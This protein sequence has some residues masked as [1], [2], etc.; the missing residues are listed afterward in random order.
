MPNLDPKIFIIG[1]SWVG[2]MVMAQT[3]FKTLKQNHPN[4]IIDVMAPAWSVPLMER[5]PEINQGLVLPFAHGQGA[6]RER[7]HMGKVLRSAGYDRAYVLPNSWKSALIPWAAKIPVRTGWLG[8]QRHILLNDVRRLDKA[9]YPLMIERF[10]ALAGEPNVPLLEPIPKP[11]FNIAEG[12]TAQAL[13][14]HGLNGNEKPI[15]ALCPGSEFGSSKRWPPEYFADV[16]NAKLAEGWVVWLF[17]S[18]KDAEIA[19]T[20][21]E[22]TQNRCQNLTGETSLSEAVDLMSLAKALVTNDSGLMHIAAAL[23]IPQVVPFGSTSPKFTPPLSDKATILSLGLE[24]APCFKRECPLQHHRC[25]RD[26]SPSMVLAA[27]TKV[28]TP[29]S[30]STQ[31]SVPA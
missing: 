26:L 16:A 11:R 30:S 20:I 2:D 6:F 29:A 17:G 13:A 5:M 22:K 24:C 19:N 21:Q 8:E 14:K 25:M 10:V 18:P 9:R 27:L 4:A 15:L 31:N 1:P 7:Y 23:D 28:Q 3:L 12:S